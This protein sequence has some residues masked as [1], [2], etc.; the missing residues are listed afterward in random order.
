MEELELDLVKVDITKEE[1]QWLA[2]ELKLQATPTVWA[3]I[4]GRA[5][6]PPLVGFLGEE[7]YR[8]AFQEIIAYAKT[9]VAGDSGTL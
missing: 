1:N 9:R 7:G 5:V 2:Q 3:F 4:Q 8:E 6:S